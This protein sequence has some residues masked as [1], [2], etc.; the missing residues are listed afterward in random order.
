MDVTVENQVEV[1]NTS[2]LDIEAGGIVEVEQCSTADLEV[3]VQPKEYKIVGDGLY[4][5]SKY[6]DAPGW[7][8]NLIDQTVQTSIA[9]EKN[10]LNDVIASL[11]SML[12]ELEIAKNTYTQSIISS[13]DIDQRINTA[14]TTLNSSLAAADANIL[15]IAQ[16]ATTPEEASALAI[17]AINAELSNTDVGTLGAQISELA[18]AIV[19]GDNAVATSVETLSSALEGEVNARASAV[20]T[21]RTYVGIDAA[22]ASTGTGLSGYI[23]D[24]NTGEFGGA[25]SQLNNTISAR[26]TDVESKFEY[27]SLLNING[28]NYNSGFGLVSSATNT[29][30]IT[31]PVDI[32]DSE[33]WIRADKFRMVTADQTGASQQPFYVNGTTGDIVFQGK[34]TFGSSQSGTID[35]AISAVVETVSVGDKNINITDNLIPTTSLVA[36]T[37]NSGYQFIGDPVK[38]SA[39]GIATF[40]EAQINLDA[41]DEVYSPYVDELGISY[42]YRFGIKGVVATDVDKFKIVTVDSSDV[43]TYNALTVSN[44]T[45]PVDPAEWYIVEGIINPA[46]G[47]TSNYGALRRASDYVKIGDI[48][49]F[50]LPA[51]AEKLLLGWYGSATISRM[52]LAKITAETQVGETATVDYVNS[53]VNG[54]ASLATVQAAREELAITMGFPDY[55]TMQD[56]YLQLGTT[57]INGGHLRTNLLEANSITSD[58]IQSYGILAESINTTGL[59]ADTI[60]S[61]GVIS[62]NLIKGA[63]IEGAVIRNS[64]IDLSSTGYITNWQAATSSPYPIDNTNNPYY[65]W[66]NNFAKDE[67]GSWIIDIDGYYRLPGNTGKLVYNNAGWSV[68]RDDDAAIPWTATVG[69]GLKIP[70]YD[71]YKINSADRPI[72]ISPNIGMGLASSSNV[73]IDLVKAYWRLPYLSSD[74]WK[75]LYKANLKIVVRIGDTQLHSFKISGDDY[76][77]P[78]YVYHRNELTNTAVA[79]YSWSATT[80]ESL[81]GETT[82]VW[83]DGWSRTHKYTDHYTGFMFDLNTKLYVRTYEVEYTSTYCSGDS[84]WTSTTIEE[85]GFKLVLKTTTSSNGT[86]SIGPVTSS[87]N[88]QYCNMVVVESATIGEGY[89]GD[90]DALCY[91]VVPELNI[92]LQE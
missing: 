39:V 77:E 47:D 46:G 73:V 43:A 74:Y 24:P 10:D 84:C 34:V 50:A 69:R 90:T 48:A 88:G 85:F 29:G 22:G 32:G 45:E 63:V 92:T 56:Q 3:T 30:T 18:S 11:N 21:I 62:G 57:V 59:V 37:D 6:E 20:D 16:T 60:S 72:S 55:T 53:T 17:E 35:E 76:G 82:G 25:Q 38:S 52:K 9:L 36:D 65:D 75:N 31:N 78:F 71:S 15:N 19:E 27:N 12:T 51:G 4:I 89:S 83:G 23:E 1:T 67:D 54:T 8:Q 66:R 58:Y 80:S 33:F 49:N 40:A 91:I 87:Y 42:Y 44:V 13:N 61:S 7:L 5:P 14:I 28:V 26:L 70:A 64:W 79:T 86:F 41:D 68:Y 81:G 2:I